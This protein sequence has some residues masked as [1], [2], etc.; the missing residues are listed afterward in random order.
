MTTF[1]PCDHALGVAGIAGSLPRYR[2]SELLT[3]WRA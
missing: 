1:P 2:S 3:F